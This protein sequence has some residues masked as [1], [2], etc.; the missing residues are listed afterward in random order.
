LIGG[1]GVAG[2]VKVPVTRWVTVCVLE[3]SEPH[4]TA[5]NAIVITAMHGA[6]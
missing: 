1:A 2:E 5:N 4:A 3:R 6:R